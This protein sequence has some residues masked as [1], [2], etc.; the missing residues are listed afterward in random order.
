MAD[1]TPRHDDPHDNIE[2]R[3]ARI[4]EKLN[5]L[6]RLVHARFDSE[7]RARTIQ[8]SELSRRLEQLNG[9]A[10][11]IADAI[12]ADR[13]YFVRKDIYEESYHEMKIRLD[14][15]REQMSEW[16]GRERGIQILLGVAIAVGTLLQFFLSMR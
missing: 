10:G 12:N 9:E 11:R 6:D 16:I 13:D 4:E 5:A 7:E 2:S 1:T 14:G 8:T 3:T 15:V